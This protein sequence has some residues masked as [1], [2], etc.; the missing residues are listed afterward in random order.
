MPQIFADFPINPLLP[1]G[2][3]AGLLAGIACGAVGPYVIARN[4]VFLSGAIA[5]IVVGGVGAALYFKHVWGLSWL[6][7]MYGALLFAVI[8][9]VLLGLVEHYA[10]ER[11]DTLIGALWAGGMALGL[12]LVKFTPGYHAELNSYLFGN[13]A[14]VDWPDVYFAAGLLAIIAITLAFWHKRFLALCLDPEHL[15]LQ[16]VSVLWTNILL[17]VLAALT[18][19]ILT[20]IVG[21]ILVIALL[22][23]PAASAGFF[24]RGMPMQMLVAAVLGALLGTL[25]RIA[26]YGTPIAPESAIV[27]SAV[28]AYVLAFCGLLLLRRIQARA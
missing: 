17:L 11:L 25:P 5:H 7:P 1:A 16:G 20:R 6:E 2:L 4:L 19:V 14:V 18:V 3:L 23:L 15:E 8:A 13:L 24:C 21:L 22:A 28:A 26:V 12:T 27:L 9:A 10:H